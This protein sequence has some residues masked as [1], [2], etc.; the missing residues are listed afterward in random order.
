MVI[1]A[2][3]LFV[4]TIA[5]WFVLPGG[6]EASQLETPSHGVFEQPASS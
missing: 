3:L 4:V 6:V 1:V 2:L 5:S